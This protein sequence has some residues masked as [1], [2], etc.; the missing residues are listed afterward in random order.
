MAASG[1]CSPGAIVSTIDPG[2]TENADVADAAPAQVRFPVELPAYTG[3]LEEL[4]RLGQRGEIDLSAIPVSEVTSRYRR[5]I[6]ATVRSGEEPDLREISEFLALVSRL[7]TQKAKVALPGED[8]LESDV[9]E[10]DPQ[11]E[12]GR[13]LAE[14][15]LFRA[16][17]DA[18]LG[19]TVDDG[20]RNFLGLVVP[21]VVPVERL[22]IAPEKLAA[23]FR[24]VLER[25]NEA[26]PLPIGVMTF[27]VAEVTERLRA[28]LVA[29]RRLDFTEVFEEA[30]SKLEAVAFFLAL[31]ELIRVGEAEV[32]QAGALEP[33]TVS[34]RGS[35]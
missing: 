11:T 4:V 15:R 25:F 2:M 5:Q 34:I 20:A 12:A 29:A 3:S 19:G 16:A 13:R 35:E 26:E 7:I 24:T 10:A 21:E 14:Y 33:I 31:L 27:S 17:A 30:G 6:E 32:N 1:P 23:A 28:R 18:L 22:H 9:I 8:E